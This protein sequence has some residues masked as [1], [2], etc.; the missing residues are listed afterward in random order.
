M[1][2]LD[3]HCNQLRQSFELKQAKNKAKIRNRIDTILDA[4]LL[5]R[6]HPPTENNMDEIICKTLKIKHLMGR[7]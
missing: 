1:N 3:E 5:Y 4:I 2:Q 7:I 6:D